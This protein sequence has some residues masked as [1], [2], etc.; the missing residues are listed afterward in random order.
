M[1]IE[2]HIERND[3]VI[4][5]PHNG[6]V[7]VLELGDDSRIWVSWSALPAFRHA[8]AVAAGARAADPL[9]RAD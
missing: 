5:A 7:F 2:L 4:F 9:R 8:L 6:N 3:K 1:T